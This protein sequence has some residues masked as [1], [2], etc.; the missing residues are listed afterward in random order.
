[1]QKVDKL[2]AISFYFLFSLTPIVFFPSTSEL[3]EFNKIVFVYLI[4]VV[5]AGLWVGKSILQGKFIFRRT[6]LDIPLVLFLLS[7]VIST[8][9]SIDW[10]TSIFGYYSRFNGGL[11][12]TISYLLLYWAYVS[13][14]DSAK[15]LKCI[16]YL[17]ISTFLVSL[18]GIAEHFGVD[19]NLWV[20]D[21]QNRVF[22]T[23]GQPN[24]LAALL[25]VVLP[26]T[27]I[28]EANTS[29]KGK[30]KNLLWS[31]V[32]YFLSAVF[33]LT[34]L[35][36][37]SRSG[38]IAF[39]VSDFLFAIVTFIKNKKNIRTLFI[40]N[41]IFIILTLFVGTPWTP[42]LADIIRTGWA[43]STTSSTNTNE[44]V[45]ETGG[46]ES[47]E[48]RKIVW[49]GAID[50]WKHYSLLGS[51]VET[52]AYSYFQFRPQEHN[53]VSEWDYLYNKAHNEYLNYLATTGIVGLTT[54][55][56]IIA[57]SCYILCKTKYKDQKYLNLALFAGY[58]TILITNFFG[59]SVVV[60][61]LLTF[62]YPAFATTFSQQ[63]KDV[64]KQKSTRLSLRQ[65]I[66]LA[67]TSCATAFVLYCL[68]RYWYADYLYSKGKD[69]NTQKEYSQARITLYKAVKTTPI[70]QPLYL[71][72]IA[73]SAS[74]LA[75]EMFNNSDL[76]NAKLFAETAI[77]EIN[78][79]IKISPHN[80]NYVKSRASI[81]ISLSNLD[82]K[83]LSSVESTIKSAI[84]MAP[85]DAKL[86]Y[87]LALTQARLT[88]TD[89]AIQTLEKAIELK[90]NYKDARYALGLIY[91]QRGE[92]EKAKAQFQYILDKIS[93]DDTKI[94]QNL[95]ELSK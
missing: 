94:Q 34:L 75:V 12:S 39:A 25:A 65:I 19:K 44:T 3:F 36:T 90:A 61:S 81:L 70:T 67:V 68:A 50:I 41:L 73:K 76:D 85:S 62:L 37:K 13:N 31:K 82:T 15:T 48:I 8:I 91:S 6:I 55:L 18:Y 89:E 80:I 35:F 52:F 51:G 38:L 5:V 72:E 4:T 58:L 63:E 33:F 56:A 1:M 54:Y 22:S 95:L 16:K 45:L 9:F 32:P 84:T 88:R 28:M 74:G 59:F 86:Y 46:T 17:I 7:Q 93:P 66:L 71:E 57:L 43:P 60:I 40:H 21:V 27:W 23:L 26:L 30:L 42:S 79:A 87:N 10:M 53:L 11:A 24:W 78:Q 29:S 47:G 49:K 69:L 14:M 92:K 77:Y 64:P 20:Q 2:L 83:L